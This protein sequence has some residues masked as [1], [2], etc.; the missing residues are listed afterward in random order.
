MIGLSK[1][2][3]NKGYIFTHEAVIAAMVVLLIFYMGYFSITHNILTFH[4][5]KRDIEAFEKSN[6]VVNKVFK[7]HEFPSN[8][9]TP[10]YLKFVD[11]IKER[12]YTSE[13]TIPGTFDPFSR[14]DVDEYCIRYN[15]TVSSNVNT[16]GITSF[17][18]YNFS[19]SYLKKKN[20]LIPV[21]T[22][23]YNSKRV[24]ENI[25]LGEILYLGTK[26]P[27]QL[28][29]INISA[30]K[31]VNV[32]LSVN[33]VPFNI[34]IN[35]TPKISGFGKIWEIYE[36]NEIKVLNISQNIPITLDVAYSKNTT[37]YVLKLKPADVHCIVPLKN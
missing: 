37:V 35:S 32:I 19:S 18:L 8:S 9:Y 17:N 24:S 4:E 34:S 28:E 14:S 33:G 20:L 23:R 29:Y 25:S 31:P 2:R 36:P 12:Y 22:W 5:E 27:S 6:L 3:S 13:D 10:D 26:E 30:Q 15:L 1:L 16:T 21:K 7:D 11:R